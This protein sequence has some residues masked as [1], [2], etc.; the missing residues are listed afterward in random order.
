MNSLDHRTPIVSSDTVIADT[1]VNAA[2]HN[3]DHFADRFHEFERQLDVV[4]R[5]FRATGIIPTHDRKR[6]LPEIFSPSASDQLKREL[7]ALGAII[8]DLIDY[9]DRSQA[10]D[11][12]KDHFSQRQ[13]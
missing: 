10:K 11:Y 1:D 4:V 7:R 5:Q 3:E 6:T 8:P 13:R 9:I 12:A 2:P